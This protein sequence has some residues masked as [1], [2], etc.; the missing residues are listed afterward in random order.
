M[1]SASTVVALLADGKLDQAKEILDNESTVD[2][3]VVYSRSLKCVNIETVLRFW[4]LNPYACQYQAGEEIV[5]RNLVELADEVA[6]QLVFDRIDAEDLDDSDCYPRSIE[7][8]AVLEKANATV[9]VFKR[10]LRC[11]EYDP[12]R[13]F[14]YMVNRFGFD[15]I[16]LFDDDRY[17]HE[18]LLSKM[19]YCVEWAKIVKE[20][21]KKHGP[22]P[23][24][25]LERMVQG[26]I[27]MIER[28]I[29]REMAPLNPSF[30]SSSG[31]TLLHT[32]AYANCWVMSIELIRVHGH[33]VNV[34]NNI[35]HSP[36]Y[37]VLSPG[38]KPG[39]IGVIQM[40]LIDLMIS[41]G[42][43]VHG[44]PELVRKRRQQF[45]RFLILN[46]IARDHLCADVVNRLIKFM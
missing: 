30:R 9:W 3:Q 31:N 35:F 41:H 18:S 46:R 14:E 4:V 7:M 34:Y 28:E 45:E 27:C 21:V 12:P 38:Y 1:V 32:A 5:R 40:K 6:N 20:A 8:C 39:N 33:P 2:T 15:Y 16:T 10:F 44:F 24:F 25:A 19:H 13:V 29:V 26:K 37:N 22:I 11:A 17:D 42:A 23:H 43:H 36:L